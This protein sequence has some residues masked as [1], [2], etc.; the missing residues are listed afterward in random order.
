M[1]LD[2]TTLI[3]TG[4]IVIFLTQQ[5]KRWVAVDF[6][7]LVAVVL[8][9]G[10]QLANDLALAAD[11]VTSGSIWLTIVTGAGVGM[12]A[13]GAYDLAG[14]TKT[15]IPPATLDVPDNWLPAELVAPVTGA[16]DG[17]LPPA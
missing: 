7:P 5:A 13:G 12:V 4:A 1:E 2:P 10:I 6:L 3:A 11:P 15:D 14:R 16:E 9:I 8:G 17:V